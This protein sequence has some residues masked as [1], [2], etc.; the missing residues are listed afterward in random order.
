VTSGPTAA[1]SSGIQADG[2]PAHA[3]HMPAQ[4][5]EKL[6]SLRYSDTLRL[7]PSEDAEI[8]GGESGPPDPDP[9][10]PLTPRVLHSNE[11][12]AGVQVDRN[13]VLCLD[14]DELGF[15]Q[16]LG[17]LKDFPSDP[18]N[19]VP[20]VVIGPARLL[21]ADLRNQITA[22]TEEGAVYYERPE[23]SYTVDRVAEQIAAELTWI[24]EGFQSIPRGFV[25]TSGEIQ[26]TMEEQKELEFYA[27]PPF[28]ISDVDFSRLLSRM[29]M[30]ASDQKNDD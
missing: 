20:A 5:A 6:T 9:V 15:D 21:D 28:R 8:T 22:L 4:N 13:S 14:I 30:K 25:R 19:D 24:Y 11:L 10:V 3:E 29:Q 23:G 17:F 26:L 1:T 7:M 12:L 16:V 18:E 2:T 27:E